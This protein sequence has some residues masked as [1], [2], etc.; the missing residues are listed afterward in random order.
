MLFIYK[1]TCPGCF[2]EYVGKTDRNF[3]TRLED[4]CNKVE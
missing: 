4:H 1:I 2:K 3:M